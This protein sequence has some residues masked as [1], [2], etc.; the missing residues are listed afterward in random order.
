MGPNISCTFQMHFLNIQHL[1]SLISHVWVSP[2]VV[3]LCVCQCVS[4]CVLSLSVYVFVFLCLS[5]SLCRSLSFSVSLCV[6]VSVSLCVCHC[7]SLSVF[8]CLSFSQCLCDTLWFGV[9][10]YLVAQEWTLRQQVELEQAVEV[11]WN[12]DMGTSLSRMEPVSQRGCQQ[13][14]AVHLKQKDTVP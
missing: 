1:A 13:G 2:V 11:C 9:S 14:Q 8:V 6:C 12:E 7:V 3:R 5:V 4:M 10:L